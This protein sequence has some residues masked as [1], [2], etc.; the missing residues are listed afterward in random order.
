[1]SDNWENQQQNEEINQSEA[2]SALRLAEKYPL[3]LGKRP[4]EPNHLQIVNTFSS[5]GSLRPVTKS[6]LDIKGMMTVSGSRPITA[7]HLKISEEFKVMGNRPV[8]SNNIDD[9]L[10][11]M[12][13]LD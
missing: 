4:I 13:Y 8:A 10:L 6:G 12:G 1:M 9:N 11:L 5:V 7:S 3:M 2:A